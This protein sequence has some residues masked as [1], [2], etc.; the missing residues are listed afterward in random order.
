MET[1]VPQLFDIVKQV[2][3]LYNLAYKRGWLTTHHLYFAEFPYKSPPYTPDFSQK[4]DTISIWDAY[5][6]GCRAAKEFFVKQLK[7]V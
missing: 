6:E 3:E 7:K 1:L 4:F 5:F 2:V